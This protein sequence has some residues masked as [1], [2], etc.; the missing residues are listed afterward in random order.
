[1]ISNVV[2]GT[3]EK[4][5]YEL[6]VLVLTYE[7][8]EEKILLTIA[9]IME[10]KGVELQIILSDDGSLNACFHKCKEFM[11]I[12]GFRD[13]K[14]IYHDQNGGTVANLS[15]ALDAADGDFIKSLG[16]GDC[17][18]SESIVRMWLD[19][20]KKKNYQLSFC[21]TINY[22]ENGGVYECIVEVA[23]PQKPRI[24]EKS[25]NLGKKYYLLY[26]DIFSGIAVMCKRS[27]MCKYI[28]IIKD[29]VKYAED[30]MFRFMMLDGVKCSYFSNVAVYYEWGGISTKE[31]SEFNK[32]IKKDWDETTKLICK[33][34]KNNGIENKIRNYLLPDGE[35][36]SFIDKIYSIIA[37]GDIYFHYKKA[38]GKKRLTSVGDLSYLYRLK[39]EVSGQRYQGS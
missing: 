6:S 11:E 8:P 7:Q 39:N 22:S 19:D 31:D 34:C 21:D 37:K 18:S 5:E 16:P 17:F 29:I 1:M 38:D 23:H 25:G 12:A 10:Q 4:K 3:G 24:Y 35:K 13:Y 27:L 28:N 33:F 14:I 30:N 36:K 32:A 9:S 15:D 26:N 20:T 2:C